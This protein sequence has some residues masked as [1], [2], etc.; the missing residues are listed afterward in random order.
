M[1]K[2]GF[3]GVMRSREHVGKCNIKWPWK[4]AFGNIG[5]RVNAYGFRGL[6]LVGSGVLRI[7]AVV[8]LNKGKKDKY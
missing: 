1:E 6:V 2:E 3:G 4:E 8:S 7:A 5:K